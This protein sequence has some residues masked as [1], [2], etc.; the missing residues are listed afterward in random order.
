MRYAIRGTLT[1][2]IPLTRPLD[3][4]AALQGADGLTYQFVADPTGAVL[5]Q[6][7]VSLPTGPSLHE[8]AL[9]PSQR[10]GVDFEVRWNPDEEQR[11]RLLDQLD[12]LTAQLSFISGSLCDVDWFGVEE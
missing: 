4:A 6:I 8:T 3:D 10:P 2:P 12:S 5:T 9:S 1:A 7:G 11:R